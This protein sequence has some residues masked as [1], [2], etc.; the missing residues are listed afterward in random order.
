MNAHTCA[1]SLALL[2]CLVLKSFPLHYMYLTAR[3]IVMTTHQ[4]EASVVSECL[5]IYQSVFLR[6]ENR[7]KACKQH[8]SSQP[9]GTPQFYHYN[10]IAAEG[11][12][13][14]LIGIS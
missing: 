3:I 6:R 2:S 5:F 1:P 12:A 11:D 13:S 14:A 10:S 8:L 9:V 4:G 7:H